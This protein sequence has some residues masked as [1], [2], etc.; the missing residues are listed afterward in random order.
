IRILK[1]SDLDRYDLSSLRVVRT[2]AAAFDASLARE[3][4]ERLNCKV[5]IA[6]GSMETFSFAQSGVDDPQEKRLRTLGKPFPGNEIKIL[7]DNGQEVP[8]G[9]T[10][11]LSVSGAAT[12]SGYYGDLDATLTAWGEFGKEGWFRT[13]DLARLDEQGYLILVGRKKEMII[14]GG[15]NIYPGE[16]EDMLLSHPMVTQAV[17]VGIPDPIMG[18]RACA[19][20]TLVAGQ[21]L[22]FEEIT[23]FL[24]E[25]GLAAHKLPERLE[26]LEQFPQLVDGQ[27]VDK[28]SLTKRIVEKVEAEGEDNA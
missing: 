7:D 18:E 19:C 21:E 27:K 22:A 25:K 24:R 3:T 4:E 5:L 10:G 13:G 1:E 2:G 20:V 11:Q 15:Q 28:I 14:R 8:M 6:G 26:V 17:V 9:E 23:S 16:I 12:S